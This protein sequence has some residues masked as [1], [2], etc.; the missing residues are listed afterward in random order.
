MFT[1]AQEGIHFVVLVG[2]LI[3]E[4]NIH[5]HTGSSEHVRTFEIVVVVHP[6]SYIVTID[7]PIKISHYIESSKQINNIII[8][9]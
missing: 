7:L 1:E 9:H 6:Y 3:A 2:T 8:V 4:I 5:R